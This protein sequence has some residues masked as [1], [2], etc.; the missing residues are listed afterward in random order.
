MREG[1]MRRMPRYVCHKEVEAIKIAAI[2]FLEDG[3]AKIAPA[4]DEYY[5]FTTAKPYI[6]K[7]KGGLPGDVDFDLGY[8]VQYADGY[9]S[10]SPTKAFEDGYTRT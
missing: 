8:Y 4:N 3:K 6:E 10:W 1:E 9:A 2:E 5:V 7:Y